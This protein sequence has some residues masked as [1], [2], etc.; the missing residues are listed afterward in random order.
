MGARDGGAVM[1]VSIASKGGIRGAYFAVL[2]MAIG[3]GGK[4][5]DDAYVS[6]DGITNTPPPTCEQI[7]RHVVDSCF[8]NGVS[9]PCVR[10]CET[11]I[12]TY[13]GCDGLNPFLRCNVK[14]RVVCTDMA[15]IDDCYAERNDLT[16]CKS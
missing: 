10:D 6:G 12:A 2:L 7:C 11:M 13:A 14:A 15:V 8:P 16:R 4:T 3:C 1:K 5:T 9:E